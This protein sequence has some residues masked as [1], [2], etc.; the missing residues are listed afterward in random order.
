[1]E[2][3]ASIDRR[4]DVADVLR[5]F[6][7]MGIVLLHSVEHFNFYAYPDTANQSVWL[8]FTDRAVWDGLFFMFGGK[9][10]AIFALLFGFSFFIMDDNQRRRGYDFR[11]R[12]CWRLVLLFLLGNLNASFFT[13][14]VLVLYSIVGFILPLAC[15]LSDGRLLALACLLLVQPLALYFV[16][17]AASDASYVFPAIPTNALWGAAYQVQSSGTFWD[18]VRVNLWE[19]QLASLAWS[20]DNGRFFQT[21]ALFL[22]GLL[23]GRRGLFRRE[24]RKVWSRVL[25]WALAAF[26]PLYGLNNMLPDF[27][28]NKSVLVPLSMLVSSLHKFA[29]TL[30]LVSCIIYIYYETGVGRRL[31]VFAPYGRMS[32]TNYLTQSVMGAMIFYN[33]GFGLY[34]TLG[35]T[36]SVGVGVLLFLLQLSFCHWWMRRHRHGP[37]EYL[38]K[39]ATWAGRS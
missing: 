31:F 7:V 34:R 24:H 11:L 4:I 16:V 19:G 20:W 32:L 13:G 1:M 15:R 17:R 8:N 28:V 27:I 12:F 23:I 5:G 26:F 29:F 10:Y 14:E 33:W 3:P 2:T 9:G 37:F 22:F 38:W 6:A 18:T 39:K 36:A 25:L 21:A 30:I 35:I